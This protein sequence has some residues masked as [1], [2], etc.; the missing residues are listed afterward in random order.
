M[1]RAR[2]L[3]VGTSGWH[4]THWKGPFYPSHLATKEFLAYYSRYFCTTEINNTFYQPAKKKS[5]TRW[6]NTVPDDFVFSVKASRYITHYAKL[7]SPQRHLSPF[8]EAIQSLGHQLGCILFQLP[9]RWRCNVGRLTSFLKLL[10]EQ[11]RYTFEFRDPSWFCHEVYEALSKYKVAFC[12]YELGDVC[13]PK[14]VTTDFV[15]VRLHG[16]AGPYRGKYS[17]EQLAGWVGAFS[18]WQKQDKTIYCYFDNDEK[19]FAV[20]N[21]LELQHMIVKE[22]GDRFIY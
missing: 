13:S 4:Y 18:S 19:G 12:I 1:K 17:T 7:K 9:P 15:Y 10:P 5:L 11:Y 16:P 22:K 21:A 2:H 20:A 14:K 8:L 3:H 6:R